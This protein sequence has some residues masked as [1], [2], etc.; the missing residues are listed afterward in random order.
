M[1]LYSAQKALVATLLPSSSSTSFETLSAAFDKPAHIPKSFWL[2]QRTHLALLGFVSILLLLV[3]FVA[4]P[5]S[6]GL[7]KR[8]KK[9]RSSSSYQSLSSSSSDSSDT[10]T[11]EE[12]EL[13]TKKALKEAADAFLRGKGWVG[14]NGGWMILTWSLLR[15]GGLVT[16][17][18]LNAMA[19]LKA[20][21]TKETLVEFGLFGLFSYLSILSVASIF[22]RPSVN[23]S[24]TYALKA[25]IITLLLGVWCVYAKRDIYPMIT[26]TIRSSDKLDV[27]MWIRLGVLTFTAL[28][29]PLFTPRP[30]IPLDPTGNSEPTAEQTSSLFAILFFTFLDPLVFHAW[31][32][33]SLPFEDLPALGDHDK[34]VYLRTTMLFQ[35]D[36]HSK[37]ARAPKNKKRHLGW[38]ILRVWWKEFAIKC[39][40]SVLYVLLEFAAPLGVNRLLT[41]LEEEGKGAILKPWVYIVAIGVGPLAQGI[42]FNIL[43]YVSTRFMCRAESILTQVLFEHSLRIQLREDPTAKKEGADG[44]PAKAG[45]NLVGQISN[46]M[47]SDLDSLIGARMIMLSAIS[48]PLGIAVSVFGLY[49]I[50]GWSAFVGISFLILT[51]P[52]PAKLA[53]VQHGTQKLFTEAADARVTR[54]TEAINSLRITKMFGIEENVKASIQELRAKE[55]KLNRKRKLLSLGMSVANYTLPL[56]VMV[57]T[58]A[59]FAIVQKGNLTASKVFS[60]ISVFAIFSQSLGTIFQISQFIE[61]FVALGRLNKF[62]QDTELID[63]HIPGAAEPAVE[64]PD[65]IGFQNA[66]F[67]WLKNAPEGDETVRN[68]K[69]HLDDLKFKKG[70]V[71]LIEGPT[72]SG[73]TS[74]FMALLGEMHFEQKPGSSFSLPRSGGVAYADQQSWLQNQTLRDNILFGSPYDEER[75][76]KVVEQCALARDFSLFD[77]GDLTE[78]GEKG[79]TL[80]GGQKA[81]ITLAR[82]V[83]SP[84]SILLL[85]DILSALDVQTSRFIIDNC[86]QGDILKGRTVILITHHIAMAGPAADFLVTLQDGRVK[87]QGSV[88]EVLKTDPALFVEEKVDEGK[89]EIA[90]EIDALEG[91]VDAVVEKPVAKDGKLV[92]AEEKAEGRVSRQAINLLISSLGGWIF[93]L[94]VLTSIVLDQFL[95]LAQTWW[96]GEWA[97]QY[98]PRHPEDASNVSVKFYLF[99]YCT[100]VLGGTA[101]MS[102]GFAVWAGGAVRSGMV[103]HKKLLTSVFSATLRWLDMTPQGRI[104]SRFTRD[105]RSIDGEFTELTSAVLDMGIT[106]VVKLAGITFVVPWFSAAGLVLVLFGSAIAELYIHAQLS[107]KRE[108]SNAKSPLFSHFGDAIAGLVSVR[109]YGAEK[110]VRAEGVK[111]VD[112]YM[113]TIVVFYNLNRWCNVRFDSLAAVF[114]SALAAYL[115]YG[116]GERTASAIGFTLSV[117]VQFS[118]LI[119]WFVR[120]LNMWEV[121]G[122]SVERVQDYLVIEREKENAPDGVPPAY[123]PA[124]GSIKIENLSARYSPD[125]PLVLDNI[126]LEINSG[127][128]IGVVGRTGSGKSTLALALLRLIPTTGDVFIDDKNYN[129]INLDALRSKITII[130]QDPTLFSGSVRLNIDPYSEHDDAVLLAA[131]KSSGLTGLQAASSGDG[132]TTPG[133]HAINLDTPITAGGENLSSG[134]RQLV[135]LARGFVRRSK[136]FIL[137]EATSSIDFATDALIQTSIRSEL[138]GIT[139]ITIAH[140]LRSILDYDRILV[141]SAG[142]VLEFD[143]PKALLSNP[144]GE[145]TKLVDA[146]S[147]ADELRSIANGL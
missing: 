15:L 13:E 131:L 36:P 82:A 30:Y 133:G 22:Y 90:A 10:L 98:D 17:V 11:Q 39:V 116:P 69:L 112:R 134:Q 18:V 79:L 50:L 76:T 54:I 8:I 52:L 33:P 137:D 114:S 87:A 67:A 45:G 125:G 70:K 106:L 5:A 80:S 91:P 26:F 105:M 81:R 48:A 96:L 47:S 41:Y 72:G 127:E 32:L 62:L 119:L 117:S 25:H 3:Q 28:F 104:V 60:A 143:T 46:H 101:A 89:A 55:L 107:C 9:S 64:D 16:L 19:A 92:L 21:G 142:K 126:N 77:A 118:T 145:L 135:A 59:C 97:D 78:V 49:K 4:L 140:R 136:V 57:V 24:V 93:W 44:E 128:R 139:L 86:L 34:A 35:L 37:D 63:R 121:A 124:S 94:V 43:I 111:R 40:L 102:I 99:Y 123:W 73:K 147:D 75:Y 103:I 65:F 132:T 23:S 58:F 109:A 68:F 110:Q 83:Y 120:V 2:D 108:M 1:D 7:Y 31:S 66:T 51:S 27:A 20:E 53:M 12:E 95:V 88:N 56:L 138:E 14:K 144:K 100:L 141:L 42:T 71:N 74:L 146:S 113:R 38:R 129:D 61:S 122:N 130:P 84:A 29:P 115:V 6:I 85:D